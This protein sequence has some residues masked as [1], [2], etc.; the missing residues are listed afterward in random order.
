MKHSKRPGA[1]SFRS[2][3]DRGSVMGQNYRHLIS[4]AA[5]ENHGELLKVCS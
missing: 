2:E 5:R 3:F 1:S 4:E